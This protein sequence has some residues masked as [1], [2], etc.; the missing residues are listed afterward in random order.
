MC[1][2]MCVFGLGR[3]FYQVVDL[4][5]GRER[6]KD[7]KKRM[8]EKLP[9]TL[10]LLFFSERLVATDCCCFLVLSTTKKEGKTFLFLLTAF[11]SIQINLVKYRHKVILLTISSRNGSQ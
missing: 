11:T 9:L 7:N 1:T 8:I 3:N 4:I 10:P 6:Q 5:R 2:Q